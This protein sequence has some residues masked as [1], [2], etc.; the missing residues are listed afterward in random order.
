MPRRFTA[1]L[2]TVALVV[3]SAAAGPNPVTAAT[4]YVYPGCGATIQDCVNGATSGDT[5]LVNADDAGVAVSFSKSLTL[6]SGDGTRHAVGA[7][8]IGDADTPV[9]IVVEGFDVSLFVSAG[10]DTSVGSSLVMRNVHAVAG[11]GYAAAIELAAE[12]SA[13]FVLERSAGTS[14]GNDQAALSLFA[15]LP[16]GHTATFKIIGNRLSGHGNAAS[17]VGIGLQMIGAGTVK[18]DILNN[19]VWDVGRSHA[20]A[21]SGIAIIPSGTIQADVNIVGNTVERSNT[22]GLQQRNTLAVGGQLRLDLFNNIFSHAKGRGIAL[23]SGVGSTLAFRGGY[24][25]LYANGSNDYAGQHRGPG[26]TAMAPGFVNRTLGQ[27]SLV[28][29]SPL[30]DRG[31]VCSPG[32]IAMPDASGTTRLEGN[33][34]D[35]GAYERGN[36]PVTGAVRLGGGAANHLQGTNGDDILCG[37]AGNDDLLGLAGD[38]YLGA[39]NGADHGSGGPG[40]DRLVGGVGPDHLAG[41]RD[42]DVLCANDGVAANDTVDGEDGFDRARTDSGDIRKSIEGLA[43]C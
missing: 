34:V 37:F 31:Q 1:A 36:R 5:I 22:D 33:G 28:G 6:A 26:N 11:P 7:I 19:V 13:S 17:G 38:D 23:S 20:G 41:G 14:T 27:L 21:A 15:N 10:F 25:D 12:R 35:I 16:A 3:A 8:S 42:G 4:T 32:G 30:I 39:G 9:A 40:N 18:A 29:D 24:N 43:T 2:A